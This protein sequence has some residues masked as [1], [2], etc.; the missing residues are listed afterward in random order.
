[1]PSHMTLRLNELQDNRT[2]SSGRNRERT[3]RKA[4]SVS[5]LEH[6]KPGT[7]YH[8]KVC[9]GICESLSEKALKI[10]MAPFS[11][12][13]NSA[14]RSTRPPWNVVE[15]RRVILYGAIP[16]GTATPAHVVGPQNDNFGQETTR[17]T[18][19]DRR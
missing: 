4:L 10:V 16:Y 18:L 11:S 2:G 5:V 17:F 8:V 3:R 1:M 13:G 9:S 6:F 7:I 15:H 19:E 12:S 14:L